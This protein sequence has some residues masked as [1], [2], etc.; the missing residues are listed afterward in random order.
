MNTPAAANQTALVLHY[1]PTRGAA[2][3]RRTGVCP[4]G[5]PLPIIS[6]EATASWLPRPV[7]VGADLRYGTVSQSV[8][9]DP[10]LPLSAAACRRPH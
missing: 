9:A 1:S 6:P 3:H 8:P 7:G 10:N 4:S 5:E 2:A